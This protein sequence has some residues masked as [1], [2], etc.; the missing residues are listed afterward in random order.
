MNKALS[1]VIM[2]VFTFSCKNTAETEKGNLSNS[3]IQSIASNGKSSTLFNYANFVIE[4]GKIGPIRI[5]MTIDDAEKELATLDKKEVDAID[6][7]YDGGGK[8]YVYSENTEPVLAILPV[9][10]SNKILVIIALSEK[11]KTINGLHANVSVK[12]IEEKC[13]NIKVNQDVMMGWE[14]MHDEQ[15]NF[16]FI[17]MTDQNNKIGEYPVLEAPATPKRKNI[18]ADW[19]TIK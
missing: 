19:I 3:S 5:G 1:L 10:D 9:L 13:P 2:V 15:N 4:K 17:F 11:L 12:E 6:F 7:G 8:A 16:D 18:K 14:F